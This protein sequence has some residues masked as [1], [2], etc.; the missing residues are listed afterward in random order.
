[1]ETQPASFKDRLIS[2]ISALYRTEP[3]LFIC[4]GVLS[5]WVV[6]PFW[7]GEYLPFLDMPQ[8]LATIGVMH[9][10]DDTAFDHAA[11]FTVD[12]SSTQYLLYYLSCDVMADWVGVENANRIFISL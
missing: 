4:L 1:M 9:H 6:C 11:Y 5:C 10:Y 3:L 8:H 12:L 7:I 2:A